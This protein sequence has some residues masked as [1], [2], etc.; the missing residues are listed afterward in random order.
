MKQIALATYVGCP[1][2][3]DDDRLLIPALRRLDIEAVPAV[4]DAAIDWAQFDQVIL[5]SCW[6]YHLRYNEFRQ[7]VT[8]LASLGVPLHN[9]A[10]LVCWNAD[11][12]ICEN[13]KMRARAYPQ[14][15][16]LMK[17]KTGMCNPF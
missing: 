4:W 15:C 12:G 11:K 16:G 7:W 1:E 14:P 5:R 17:K 6:D 3:T 8:E 10:S 13:L 9:S 2:L